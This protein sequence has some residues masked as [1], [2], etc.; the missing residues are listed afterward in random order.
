MDGGMSTQL[1]IA[2]AIVIAFVIVYVLGLL[3]T[4]A[5]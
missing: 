4:A 3:A 1:L 2:G 5:P